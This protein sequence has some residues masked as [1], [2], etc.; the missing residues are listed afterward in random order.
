[1][2]RIWWLAVALACL[3]ADRPNART[4]RAL[5]GLSLR[6]ENLQQRTEWYRR[7]WDLQRENFGARGRINA[8]RDESLRAQGPWLQ[9]PPLSGW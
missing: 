6:Y 1:M 9:P 5:N 4:A 2:R 3:G 7:G 8:T